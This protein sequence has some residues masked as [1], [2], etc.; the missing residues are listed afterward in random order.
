MN[1]EYNVIRTD[2]KKT[3]QIKVNNNGTV[4]L[5]VPKN[6]P[7]AEI[8]D[9]LSKKTPWI[10]KTV[11]SFLESDAPKEFTDD[12]IAVLRNKALN[13]IPK[14]V[15]YY[16][17]LMN[18]KPSAVKINSA[19]SR[20]GSCSA[21]NSLNFSV[22]LMDKDERFIDYVVVHEL[23]HILQHNHSK[24]FYAEIEKILPDYK[25]RRKLERK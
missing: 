3:V 25:E 17:K 16:S 22:F 8:Q 14:K 20:Y 18:V 1:F 4:T 23:A 10:E 2:R 6:L 11:K 15:E 21:K 12:N 7:N 19:K 9:I 13:V 24:A 5:R